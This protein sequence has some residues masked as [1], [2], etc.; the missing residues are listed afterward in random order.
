MG[1]QF[2][3]FKNVGDLPGDVVYGTEFQLVVNLS[4]ERKIIRYPTVGREKSSVCEDDSA[5]MQKFLTKQS[6][7][8]VLPIKPDRLI[9][10]GRF[11][12]LRHA[13]PPPFSF[14]WCSPA[15]T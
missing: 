1:F 8:D 11:P 9:H 13:A 4:T 12:V 5:L 2:Q 6:F 3:H 7:V 10:I 14:L 15:R